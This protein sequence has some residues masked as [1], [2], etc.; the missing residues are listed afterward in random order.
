MANELTAKLSADSTKLIITID[1]N[2]KPEPSTSGKTL[3]VAS[4]GGFTKTAAKFKGKEI[5]VSL[6]ATVKP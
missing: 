6:N 1:L 3:V 4:S 2:Q 5:S